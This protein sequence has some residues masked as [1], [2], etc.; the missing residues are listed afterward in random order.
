MAETMSR[1]SALTLLAEKWMGV[2]VSWLDN[3]ISF[4]SG[5]DPAARNPYTGARGLIQFMPDTAKALGYAS[6]DDLYAKNQTETAQLLGPVAA[7]FKL[8]GNQGPWPTKQSLYMSVFYPAYR[9]K[10]PG[11]FFSNAVRAVNPGID[12][13]QDYVSLVDGVPIKKAGVLLPVVIMGIVAAF[14]YFKKIGG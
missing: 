8:P 12:T 5:W 10:A 9:N 2:P 6:A 13:V 14:F 4:E 1:S 11:T 7:Y 3:L